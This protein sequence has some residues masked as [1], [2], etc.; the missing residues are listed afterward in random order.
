MA[1]DSTVFKRDV[2]SPDGVATGLFACSGEFWTLGLGEVTFSLRDI[3]GLGCIQRLLQRPGEEIPALELLKPCGANSAANASHLERP[4]SLPVGVTVRPGLT[5]DAGEM[6]DHQAKLEYRRKIS[7]LREEQDEL[8]DRGDHERVEEIESEIQFLTH[9]L[10][11]ALDIRGRARRAGSISERARLN[12]RRAIKAALQKTSERHATMGALLEQTIR[13]GTFC[14]YV[15]NPLSPVAWQF[16]ASTQ[17]RTKAKETTERYQSNAAEPKNEPVLW[18]ERQPGSPLAVLNRGEFVGRRLERDELRKLID[19]AKSGRGS[20]VTISGTSGVGKT[21]LVAEVADEV[22]GSMQILLGRCYEREAIAPYTPFVE[23]LETALEHALSL[24]DFRTML[25]ANGAELVRMMPQ[26]RRLFPDLES[27]LEGTPDQQRRNLVK[28]FCQFIERLT[29]HRPVMLILDDLQWADEPSLDL[30]D[31]LAG[32][33][34]QL[35]LVIISTYRDQQNDISAR[36]AQTLETL[37]RG[38][39]IDQLRLRGLNSSEVAELLRRIIGRQLSASLIQEIYRE[40]EGNPFFVEE[41]LKYL[42]EEKNLVDAE[43]NVRDDVSIGAAEVPHN[44][45]LTIERMLQRLNARTRHILELAAVVGPRFGFEMLMSLQLFGAEDLLDATKEGEDAGIL[46]SDPGAYESELGFSHELIRQTLLAGLSLPRRQRWHFRVA[47]SIEQTY[48]ASLE[49]H[50]AEIAHHLTVAGPAGDAAKAVHYL[51]IAGKRALRAGDYADAIRQFEKAL[52]FMERLPQNPDRARIELEIKAAMHVALIASRGFL[53]PEL[54]TLN[55][56]M[57]ELCDEVADPVLSLSALLSAWAFHSNR[58]ELDRATA[59]S[60]RMMRLAAQGEF[61]LLELAANLSYGTILF[62]RGELVRSRRHLER[63][64]AVYRPQF[65]G[66]LHV[67][68]DVGVI[69]LCYLSSTLLAL[70]FSDQ[71]LAAAK[72]G[73]ELARRISDT[74]TAVHAHF[75]TAATHLARGEGTEALE[76]A[77]IVCSVSEENGYLQYLSLGTMMRGLALTELDRVA[78][79]IVEVQAGLAKSPRAGNV[80]GATSFMG[81]LAG[82]YLKAG[83][84]ELAMALLG[85]ALNMVERTGERYFESEL[86]RLKGE[87]LLLDSGE[88][89]EKKAERMFRKAS[90]LAGHFGHDFSALRAAISLCRLYRREGRVQEA[91]SVLQQVYERFTESFDIADMRCARE[92]LKE[93]E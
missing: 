10:A 68:H 66:Q 57:L 54:D 44:V 14:S 13:T 4:S 81:L 75:Q 71:A 73:I 15:P 43:G 86:Y 89:A 48:A 55:P 65:A 18:Q 20:I 72:R 36:F 79:G 1:G 37:R 47:Q 74:F 41:V 63:A 50:A 22:V 31:N 19:T 67:A 56:R 28:N 58:G 59:I 39:F 33:V 40:T 11:R 87:V 23:V 88:D 30:L 93:V 92:L 17:S 21:R 78:E 90:E 26:L 24:E 49:D 16:D 42:I 64:V 35:R 76:Q 38:H 52:G 82:A 25:G 85:N 62:A 8:R 32:R 12:V 77:E 46:I 34:R 29:Q 53:A 70:G 60:E 91:R 45:R 51:C 9:E 3:R 84:K 6:L 69:S 80:L 27:P 7:E 5:G 83:E 2:R 61:P